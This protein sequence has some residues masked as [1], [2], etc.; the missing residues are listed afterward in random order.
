MKFGVR[1]AES[2]KSSG[3]G[4]SD[5]LRYF[6]DK[7]TRLRFLE[8]MDDWTEVWMHFSPGKSRTYPCTGERESC[9]GCLSENEREA[10]AAKKYIANALQEGYVNAWILP[11]SL[12]DDM[13]RHKDKGGGTILDRDFTVIKKDTE[14][15]I[16][17]AVDRE[18]RDRIDLSK[19]DD[20]KRDHQQMLQD[21]Y[22]EVWGGLPG[23]K[24]TEREPIIKAPIRRDD[25][26]P[27]A[28]YEDKAT[29]TKPWSDEG[30]K[31]YGDPPSEPQPQSDPEAEGDQ[32][33]SENQLRAM[34]APQIKALFIQCGLIVPETDNTDELSD[35]L[36]AALA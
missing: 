1:A 19:Y 24:V 31:G 7:E 14:A 22:V 34:S 15:G 23:E 20:K 3:A 4:S 16:R 10:K 2:T 5:Y 18:E 29:T 32:E 35:Q 9:P 6:R 28:R 21:V 36:I 12:W 33:L 8:E 17:Y 27:T 30:T 26:T 11:G 13:D 25:P